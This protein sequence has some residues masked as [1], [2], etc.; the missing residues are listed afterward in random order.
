MTPDTLFSPW[1]SAHQFLQHSLSHITHKVRG[2]FWLLPFL[3]P[4]QSLIPLF[5]TSFIHLFIYQQL[6]CPF[7]PLALYYEMWLQLALPSCS[8]QTSRFEIS[9]ASCPF[10][11][12]PLVPVPTGPG[13]KLLSAN[14]DLLIQLTYGPARSI[15]LKHRD[16]QFIPLLKNCQWLSIPYCN[17]A[18]CSR[19]NTGPGVCRL[20]SG[21]AAGCNGNQVGF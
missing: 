10:H 14:A 12:D 11:S 1:C 21:R 8:L 18:C 16:D 15:F 6:P 9:P 5:S 20:G 13:L 17:A 2:N 3:L 7:M 4:S 19:R